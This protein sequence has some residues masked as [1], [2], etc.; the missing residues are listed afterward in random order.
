MKK[1][2]EFH[3]KIKIVYFTKHFKMIQNLLLLLIINDKRLKSSALHLL[4][5]FTLLQLQLLNASL[6]SRDVTGLGN[7]LQA[8]QQPFCAPTQQHLLCMFVLA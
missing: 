1:C 3:F 8:K 4:C 6:T 2:P 5:L 7:F